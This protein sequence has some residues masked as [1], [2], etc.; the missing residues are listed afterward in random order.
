MK[1]DE[2]ADSW[3]QLNL[4]VAYQSLRS[5]YAT[6]HVTLVLLVANGN[7]WSISGLADLLRLDR[8]VIRRALRRLERVDMANLEEG[9]YRLSASGRRFVRRAQRQAVAI[10][11]GRRAGF[12]EDI[13]RV[14]ERLAETSLDEARVIRLTNPAAISRK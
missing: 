8:K 14:Y 11:S 9:R 7:G 2:E 5:D 13:V 4:H 12:S 3:F 10:A 6:R 1:Y